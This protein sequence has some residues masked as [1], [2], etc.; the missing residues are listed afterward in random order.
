MVPSGTAWPP[1]A[2]RA[3]KTQEDEAYAV[4]CPLPLGY[5]LCVGPPAQGGLKRETASLLDL[6]ADFLEHQP[7]R[8]QGGGFG[9]E[10][11][12]PGGDKENPPSL[13]RSIVHL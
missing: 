13:G 2:A 1:W 10:R 4:P 12:K 5:Q 8:P 6:G 9:L 11:R 3:Q 7:P